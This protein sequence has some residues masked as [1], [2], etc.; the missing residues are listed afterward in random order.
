MLTCPKYSSKAAS[1]S[2][3]AARAFACTT[4][5]ALSHALHRA[6]LRR[7]RSARRNKPWA[8]PGCADAHAHAARRPGHGQPAAAQSAPADARAD[9]HQGRATRAIPRSPARH[10]PQLRKSMHARAPPSGAR[11]ASPFPASL[12]HRYRRIALPATA[13]ERSVSRPGQ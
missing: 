11:S 10:R 8:G 2:R 4:R 13:S 6:R 1:M 9:A 3:S 5:P 12:A 7:D